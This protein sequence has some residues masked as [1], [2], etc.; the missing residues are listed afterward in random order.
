MLSVIALA[1]LVGCD[2]DAF[3]TEN[4]GKDKEVEVPPD[5]EPPVLIHDPVSGTQIFG[6]D[7]AI[8]ATVRDEGSRIAYVALYYKNEVDGA[9][10]WERATMMPAGEVP[11]GEVYSGTIRGDD[12]RGGGV[13]YYIEA[14]DTSQNSGFAPED[15][16]SDPY[17][18]RIAE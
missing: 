14:V 6:S 15:G 12:H 7:I 2:N 5:E 9:A 18:F 3:D 10:D 8:Q 4:V 11:E 16:E 1:L 17:H 13:D